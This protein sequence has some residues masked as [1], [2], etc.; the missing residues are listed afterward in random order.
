MRAVFFVL[1]NAGL[2]KPL[3]NELNKRGIS[4]GTIFNSNGM[5]HELTK[6][7]ETQ[8]YGTLK[9]LLN[10]ELKENKT[11][12]FVLDDDKMEILIDVIED[13]VGD[14]DE[15]NSGFLFSFPVNYVKGYRP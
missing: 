13:I 7:D 2:L 15:P 11:L 8:I 14:L 6:Q 12:L 1:P 10:P 3:L 5:G 9:A 4:G